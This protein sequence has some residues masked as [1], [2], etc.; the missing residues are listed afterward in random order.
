MKFCPKCNKSP[1]LVTLDNIEF[2]VG[3]RTRINRGIPLR[4][5]MMYANKHTMDTYNIHTHMDL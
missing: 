2:D 4:F 1:N 5:N 3:I